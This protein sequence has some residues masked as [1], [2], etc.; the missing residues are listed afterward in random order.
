MRSQASALIALAA[1]VLAEGPTA[2][3]AEDPV[4]GK[5]LAERWCASCHLVAPDQTTATTDAPP[6]AEL[7]KR[8]PEE[9]EALATFLTAP[10]PPMPPVSLTRREIGDVIA[11][12]ASLKEAG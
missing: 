5:A 7:A 6:F 1:I 11:Y 3:A 9:I 8:T 12:I 2:S 10:H 4:A